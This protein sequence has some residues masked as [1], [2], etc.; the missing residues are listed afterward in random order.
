MNKKQYHLFLII[1]LMLILSSILYL[2]VAFGFGRQYRDQRVIAI[3]KTASHPALD[4]SERGFLDV[5]EKHFGENVLCDIKNADGSVIAMNTIADRFVNNESVV[6]FYTIATPALQALIRKE[7]NRPIVFSAVTDPE[8]LGIENQQNVCGVTDAI[9]AE[10][11]ITSIAQFVRPINAI[12]I[13]YN[14]AELNSIQAVA[15]IKKSAQKL[16]IVVYEIGI[17]QASDSINALEQYVGKIDA[18]VTPTDNFVASSI[19]LIASFCNQHHIPLIVSDNLLLQ[20][21]VLASFGIDYYEAGRRA[22]EYAIQILDKETTPEKIRFKSL[23]QDTLL[24]NYNV[25]Q[26]MK[27]KLFFDSL[28]MKFMY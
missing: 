24:I 15:Q 18:L 12:A 4:E 13:L 26:T 10:K 16:G 19:T 5:I 3:L 9:D 20:Y 25:Y 7:Q 1:V 11:Q 23:A 22:G 6:L 27:D 2:L 28:S 8:V 14:T 21:N 17:L